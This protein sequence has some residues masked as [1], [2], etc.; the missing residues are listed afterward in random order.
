[1]FL[2]IYELH[3]DKELLRVCGIT[4]NKSWANK[5][6]PEASLVYKRLEAFER[7]IEKDEYRDKVNAAYVEWAS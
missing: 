1:V 3:R 4:L 6:S 5:K 7:G 2:D